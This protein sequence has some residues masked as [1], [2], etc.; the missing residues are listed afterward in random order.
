MS[1]IHHCGESS[2]GKTRQYQYQCKPY[3]S[4][5][6]NWHNLHPPPAESKAVQFKMF[7]A[8]KIIFISNQTNGRCCHFCIKQVNIFYKKYFLHAYS[9]W[10][11]LNIRDGAHWL[12]LFS[13]KAA[14]QYLPHLK[15]SLLPQCVL[16]HLQYKITH[17]CSISWLGNQ[18]YCIAKQP[19]KLQP[20]ESNR[21][22]RHE[23]LSTGCELALRKHFPV[24]HYIKLYLFVGYLRQCFSGRLL[25]LRLAHIAPSSTQKSNNLTLS[26]LVTDQRYLFQQ[27]MR[28]FKNRWSTP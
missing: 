20:T 1:I 7:I 18:M 21:P 4:S 12:E 28:P 26:C 5:V 13:I 10:S 11:Y 19:H 8:F 17:C 22:K 9:N 23:L 15:D 6:H 27:G 14:C 3:D 24:L 25:G 2:R 16:W